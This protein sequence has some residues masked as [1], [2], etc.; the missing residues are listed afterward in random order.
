MGRGGSPWHL[1][2]G[3]GGGAPSASYEGRAASMS[4][5]GVVCAPTIA[6][7]CIVG[8]YMWTHAPPPFHPPRKLTEAAAAHLRRRLPR[9]RRGRSVP[10]PLSGHLCCG[11]RPLAPRGTRLPA[12]RSSLHPLPGRRPTHA[13]LLNRPISRCIPATRRRKVSGGSRLHRQP[14]QST[15]RAPRG[16]PAPRP[17]LSSNRAHLLTS[18]FPLRPSSADFVTAGEPTVAAVV[19]IFFFWL[20]KWPTI[21]AH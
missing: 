12:S 17:R 15:I 8:S 1:H 6:S 14:G 13:R 7:T 16:P 4:F 18:D 10:A 5:L 3:V 2:R 19:D 21:P 9:P 20:S 11:A